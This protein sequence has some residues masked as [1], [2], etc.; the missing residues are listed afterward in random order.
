[1]QAG[2]QARERKRDTARGASRGPE[3]ERRGARASGR[4]VSWR[5]PRT[6]S[7]FARRCGPDHARIAACARRSAA[8]REAMY[9]ARAERYGSGDCRRARTCAPRFTGG[10]QSRDWEGG[11]EAAWSSGAAEAQA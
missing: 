5:Q 7:A 2:Q 3:G 8:N 4:C 1:M 11:L 6:C 10:R 9:A